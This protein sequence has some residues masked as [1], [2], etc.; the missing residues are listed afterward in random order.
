MGLGETI[1]YSTRLTMNNSTLYQ[2]QSNL[3]TR[4]IYIA[5]MGDPTLRMDPVAPP[6]AFTATAGSGGVKLNWAASA[7]PVLG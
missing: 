7:D 1:G 3:F 6:G 2:N 5:L 4:A